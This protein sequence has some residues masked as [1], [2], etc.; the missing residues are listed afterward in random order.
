MRSALGLTAAALTG[1]SVL[2][3]KLSVAQVSAGLLG[4]G[5]AIALLGKVGAGLMAV[6]AST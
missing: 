3:V 5:A 4:P 1:T 2:Q 6:L